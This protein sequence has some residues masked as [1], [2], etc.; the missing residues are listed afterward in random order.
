MTPNE[1]A[2]SYI[3][4]TTSLMDVLVEENVALATSKIDRIIDLQDAKRTAAELYETRVHDITQQP[5]VLDLASP[6]LRQELDRVN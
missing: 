2:Q 5:E 1:I 6:A 3:D 4:V